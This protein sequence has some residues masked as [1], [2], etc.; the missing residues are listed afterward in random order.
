MADKAT[1]GE[2]DGIE[3]LDARGA[4]AARICASACVTFCTSGNAVDA[5]EIEALDG[6]DASPA[7][8]CVAFCVNGNAVD[9]SEVEA[10]DLRS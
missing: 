3:A 10:L 7:R 5:S 1:Y 2:F 4:D 6:R 8:A 9:A